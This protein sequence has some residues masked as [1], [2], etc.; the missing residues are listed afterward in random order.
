MS[1][2]IYIIISGDV[3]GSAWT[4]PA[5]QIVN[6]TTGGGA[7]SSDASVDSRADVEN[8]A[9]VTRRRYTTQIVR[10]DNEAAMA[11]GRWTLCTYLGLAAVWL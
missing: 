7:D 11:A 8:V 4:L 6:S 1:A 10:V 2:C 3:S 9:V 5:H